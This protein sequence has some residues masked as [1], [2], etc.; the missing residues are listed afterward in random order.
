MLLQEKFSLSIIT[1]Y[2]Y[3]LHP[4]EPSSLPHAVLFNTT[5]YECFRNPLDILAF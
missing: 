1:S 4:M 5:N 2:V 3:Q